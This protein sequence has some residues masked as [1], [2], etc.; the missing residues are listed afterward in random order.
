MWR[1]LDGL[2]AGN[3]DATG[4]IKIETVKSKDGPVRYL[5][6]LWRK[7]ITAKLADLPMIVADATLPFGLVQHFFAEP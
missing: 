6:L 7:D 4:R 1:A 5:R 2:I 3:V